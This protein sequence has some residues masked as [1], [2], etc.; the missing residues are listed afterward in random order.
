MFYL[1]FILPFLDKKKEINDLIK[2]DAK[3]IQKFKHYVNFKF[4]FIL[5]I[6]Y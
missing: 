1:Q 3:Y 2:S 6:N 5:K 4:T